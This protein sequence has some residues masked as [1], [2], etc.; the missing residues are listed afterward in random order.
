MPRKYPKQV[1]KEATSLRFEYIN[2]R[3]PFA[4]DLSLVIDEDDD[5]WQVNLVSW[6]QRIGDLQTD[7]IAV[8]FSRI[9]DYVMT[10]P[11]KT[12]SSALQSCK[13]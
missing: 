7:E 11:E 5:S 13:S 9:L 10:K 4:Y 12:V 8:S 3:D 1:Q 6:R 2:G